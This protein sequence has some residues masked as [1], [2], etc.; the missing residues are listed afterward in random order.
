MALEIKRIKPLFRHQ[1]AKA[2]K[3]VHKHDGHERKRKQAEPPAV[4]PAESFDLRSAF[5]AFRW[6]CANGEKVKKTRCGKQ[7]Y[8][9][10][11]SQNLHT[12]EDI[13][14]KKSLNRF[15]KVTGFAVLA[16]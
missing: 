7:R 1:R 6:Q 3:N 5:S 9:K 12:L 10:K 14:S 2:D 16:H 13:R 15:L 8:F 11:Q 4:F